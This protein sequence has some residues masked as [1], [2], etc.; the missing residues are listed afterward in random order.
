M[1]G[2][3]LVVYYLNTLLQVIGLLLIAPLALFFGR[4]YLKVLEDEEKIKILKKE[5]KKLAKEVNQQEEDTLLWLS[6]SFR[7]QVIK[8]L[9]ASSDLLSDIG[10]LT[11][12]QKGGLQKIHESAKGL[13]KLGEKLKEKIEG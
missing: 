12:R 4:Q 9:D 1:N 5:T 6:L 13:L 11:P 8:I 3:S 2:L 10:K 7:E